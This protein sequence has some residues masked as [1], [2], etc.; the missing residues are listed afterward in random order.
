M[1]LNKT[2]DEVVAVI[3]KAGTHYTTLRKAAQVITGEESP[4]GPITQSRGRCIPITGT[5]IARVIW[6]RKPHAS[7]FV[8]VHNEFVYDPDGWE[9]P[10]LLTH[11]LTEARKRHRSPDLNLTSWVEVLIKK[12]LDT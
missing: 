4:F 8:V 9:S 11:W 5:Y 12:E 7:H 6:S 3:G 2:L 1:V 10:M